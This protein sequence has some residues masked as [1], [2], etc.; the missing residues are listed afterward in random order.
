M[1]AFATGGPQGIL[2]FYRSPLNTSNV[3][4]SLVQQSYLQSGQLSCPISQI[5]YRTCYGR[6]RP[7]KIGSHLWRWCYRGGWHQSFPP[8]IRQAVLTWQKAHAKHEHSESPYHTFVHCKGFAP[9]APRRAG[10]SISVSL[11]GFPLS[12]PV[13]ISGLVGHYPTNYLIRR[14]LIMQPKFQEYFF[15]ECIPYEVLSSV[16]QGYPSLHGR[17]TTCY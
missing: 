14:S 12:R 1:D 11:S 4:R 16:F 17:L 8:L 7:N 15:P 9:A 5:I 6:F 10:T 13:R 2:A 3:S